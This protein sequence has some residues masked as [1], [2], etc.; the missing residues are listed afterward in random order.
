MVAYRDAVE[1]NA[2]RNDLLLAA[3]VAAEKPCILFVKGIQHGR[4]MTKLLERAGVQTRFVWGAL[5]H[6]ARE[7]LIRDL[8]AGRLDALVANVVFQTGVDIPQLRSA[9]IGSGGKSV[10][11]A[12]QRVGRG[13]RKAAGKTGFAVYDVLDRGCGCA[14]AA[15]ALGAK[16]TAGTHAICRWMEEHA[17]GRQAAYIGE[18]YTVS[19]R[20]LVTAPLQPTEDAKG[21]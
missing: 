11:A 6:D 21:E 12:L 3:V 9:V 7:R 13:M 1:R 8:E 16:G 15:K 18:S 2:T 19:V 14:A 17:K 4:A 5:S 10:I 20:Q